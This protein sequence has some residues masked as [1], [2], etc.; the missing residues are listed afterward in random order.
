MGLMLICRLEGNACSR[1]AVGDAEV[2]LVRDPDG[3]II[4]VQSLQ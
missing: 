4:G 1:Y 2:A 3:N